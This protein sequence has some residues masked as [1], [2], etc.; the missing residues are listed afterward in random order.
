MLILSSLTSVG[1]F[2]A[3]AMIEAR[4]V[5]AIRTR[6]VEVDL[7][8]FRVTLPHA[9]QRTESSELHF[10]VFGQIANRDLEIVEQLLE[11]SGPEIR[12]DILMAARLM[13]VEDLEDAKLAKLRDRISQVV[14][15]SLEG[16]PVQAVGFYRFGY[17]NY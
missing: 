8:E 5:I 12:H 9:A 15:E 7:G 16:N 3:E 6:L 1:C 17:M 11:R 2:N 10:H 13:S 4:R 14:N